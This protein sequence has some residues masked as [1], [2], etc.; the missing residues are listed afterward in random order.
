MWRDGPGGPCALTLHVVP[1]SARDKKVLLTLLEK[2]QLVYLLT[3][4]P[5]KQV[6]DDAEDA[7]RLEEGLDEMRAAAREL[8][9]KIREEHGAVAWDELAEKADTTGLAWRRAKRVA[10]EVLRELRPLLKDEPEAAFLLQPE[11]KAKKA[12]KKA[13]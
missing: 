3:R 12:R 11:V 10:P 4:Y 2:A 6:L 9:A 7:R 5:K 8:S 1:V 13:G